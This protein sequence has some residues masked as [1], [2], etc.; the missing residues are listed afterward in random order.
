MTWILV[1]KCVEAITNTKKAD[2]TDFESSKKDDE[3]VC[4]QVFLEFC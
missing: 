3:C 1:Y 4:F 2:H